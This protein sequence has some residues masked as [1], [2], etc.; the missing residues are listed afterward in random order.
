MISALVDNPIFTREIRRRMRGRVLAITLCVYVAA[1]CL[2]AVL[3]VG[4]QTTELM[5]RQNAA[6]TYTAGASTGGYGGGY[7]GG[8]PSVQSG[9]LANYVTM[10]SIGRGL[11]SSILAIQ[12]ILVLLVAPSLTAGMVRAEK[13]R[14]TFDFLRATA[15]SG[16]V[17]VIGA[18]LSSALYIALALGCA[19]PVLMVSRLYGGVTDLV[20]KS[21]ALLSAGLVLSAGGLAVTCAG[22]KGRT[23]GHATVA[24]ALAAL[25]VWDGMGSGLWKAATSGSGLA[26]WVSSPLAPGLG[27]PMWVVVMVAC[28]AVCAV[29]LAVAARKLFH[30]RER[31]LGYRGMT[32]LTVALLVGGAIAAADAVARM[33]WLAAAGTPDPALGLDRLDT[34]LGLAVALAAAVQ[35][36]AAL[37]PAEPGD[38][39]WRV[40]QARPAL[41]DAPED[42]WFAAGATAALMAAGAA[43]TV[44]A[45]PGRPA[46]AWAFAVPAVFL[47]GH[48]AMA[49]R[50]L[51]RTGDGFRALRTMLLFDAVVLAAPPVLLAIFSGPNGG[52]LGE[53]ITAALTVVSPVQAARATLRDG[54]GGVVFAAA[55]TLHGGFA[56]VALSAWARGRGKQATGS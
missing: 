43:L 35:V 42:L 47:A 2:W 40:K 9:G 21:L 13:E 28:G 17:Y 20:P 38:S 8:A 29:L 50:L 30:P 37:S 18:F 41:R 14:Q 39:R 31:A 54:P 26:G 6:A 48:L 15:L 36:T 22:G 11:Q 56:L 7:G 16:P 34:W 53:A 55:A 51:A 27:A 19:L 25:A 3:Q 24:A 32:V 10:T 44:W 49:R 23:G 1:M 45:L 52:L 33:A 46:A 12:A 4:W 5:A